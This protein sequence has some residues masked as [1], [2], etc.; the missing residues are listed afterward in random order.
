[1]SD[2]TR[3]DLKVLEGRV[4]PIYDLS[5]PVTDE[6]F[7]RLAIERAEELGYVLRTWELAEHMAKAWIEGEPAKALRALL[8]DRCETC[9]GRGITF[10]LMPNRH[11]E[12]EERIGSDP[13]QCPDCG[14]RGWLP[15]DG[16][17]IVWI[18]GRTG[19][20]TFD[21]A[22][23]ERMEHDMCGFRVTFSDDWLEAD[24]T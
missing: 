24:N 2:I 1:M 22:G 17:D 15:K 9:D 6:Q 20:G 16:V 10:S 13:R 14:G 5:R 18:H 21:Q 4:D 7:D 8:T 12:I 19:K 11:G 23:C 3:D